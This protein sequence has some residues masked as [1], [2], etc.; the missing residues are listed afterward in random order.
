MQL[1]ILPNGV[2]AFYV[3]TE[4]L[5]K[6]LRPTRRAIKNNSMLVKCDGAVGID[7]TL[8]TIPNFYRSSI[9]ESAL[10]IKNDF[11]YP[12]VFKTD[13]LVIVCNRTS[14]LELV[15]GSLVSKISSLTGG[16][17]WSFA[18][19]GR[20]VY[21]SNGIVTVTRSPSNDVYSLDTTLPKSTSICNYN[22]QVI[23][24]SYKE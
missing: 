21:L 5:S 15:R 14:I 17:K 8:S 9:F 6:G 3:P 12:Q 11:P 24:G 7:G 2:F 4:L 20:F 10:V 19:S 22:G 16:G 1:K 13:D 23:V 18:A